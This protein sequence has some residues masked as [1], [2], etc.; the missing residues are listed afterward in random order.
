MS[1]PGRKR[2]ARHSVGVHPVAAGPDSHGGDWLKPAQ[3]FA[4]LFTCLFITHFPLLRLPYFWDEAG[5]YVPAARDLMLTGDPV[6]FSTLSNAH[7]PLP[8]AYLALWWKIGG[9][10]PSITRI[11]MLLVAALAL[12]EVFRLA[13]RIAHIQV[14]ITAVVCTA[15]YPVFFAQSSLAHADLPAAALTLLGVRMYIEGRRWPT[16]LAFALASLAKETAIVA[17]LALAAWETLWLLFGARATA[18]MRRF[19]P[20]FPQTA[21]DAWLGVFAL[22]CA[23]LPLLVWFP[24]HFWRTGYML[25]NPEFFR[26]NVSATMSPMRMLLAVGM[27]LWQTFGYM[28]MFVLTLAAAAAMMLAPQPMRRRDSPGDAAQSRGLRQRIDFRIQA[29]LVVVIFGYIVML[30]VIGGAVL[31]RYLLPV[32]PLSI[33]IAV[34]T[35]WRRVPSWTFHT[36]GPQHGQ[37]LRI[38]GW[39]AVIVFVCSAFIAG[40]V[41]NPPYHFAP[42]DNL[43]YRDFI[44][45]HQHAT[46]LIQRSYPRARVL[47]A[48]P[49]T[50][51]LNKP[52]LGYVTTAIAVSSLENYSS[53]EIEK[54]WE[55]R[56]ARLDHY[57]VALVFSTK[58]EPPRLVFPMS[59]WESVGTRYFDHHQDVSAEQAAGRLGGYIV[60]QEHRRGEWVALIE[61]PESQGFQDAG[62]IPAA[63]PAWHPGE[64]DSRPGAVRD[65][66][67][68]P[69][70]FRPAR[71]VPVLIKNGAS[72]VP[73]TGS[74]APRGFPSKRRCAE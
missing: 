18:A 73:E 51:E 11:A 5:Y 43:T 60:M 24:Y 10:H 50:D 39:M 59:L 31:A 3:I 47:S 55:K 44:L 65:W 63:A 53:R 9:F 1:L 41:V 64:N 74:G 21:R 61:F 40:L 27:R 35:I 72:S 62:N 26:Y 69:G 12:L 22:S 6:P 23:M 58:Y 46:A 36:T 33:I 32:L 19:A 54:A 45:L 28:N 49:A 38:Q 37:G 66:L 4:L 8:M 14:A 17:P 52:Y 68:N 29:V 20:I 42:E 30:S 13:R 34:S 70:F 48:W 2:P 71:E 57:D 56:R 7:P 25:G 67:S 16:T 15:L